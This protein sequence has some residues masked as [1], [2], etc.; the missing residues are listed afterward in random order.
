MSL[1]ST[2]PKKLWYKLR[3]ATRQFHQQSPEYREALKSAAV[4]RVNPTTG[5]QANHYQCLNCNDWVML[6]EVNFEHIV[7]VES[8]DI[9]TIEEYYR[10]MT[11]WG[12]L[13]LWC[14][15][16]SKGKTAKERA[17]RGKKS[18]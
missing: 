16:C 17:S 4:K 1:K 12:N 15:S 18:T 7:P 11:D 13:E 10:L 2:L 8:K 14:K 5:R 3:Y 9:G 6:K